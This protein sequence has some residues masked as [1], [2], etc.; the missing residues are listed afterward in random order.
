M[1]VIEVILQAK[2]KKQLTGLCVSF[3]KICRIDVLKTQKHRVVSL[4]CQEHLSTTQ[5]LPSLF[6]YA[7]LLS[8]PVIDAEKYL[9]LSARDRHTNLENQPDLFVTAGLGALYFVRNG[10][11]SEE[12]SSNSLLPSST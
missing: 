1:E 8:M 9:L 12:I 6:P 2:K 5:T 11:Q 4:P 7:N 3:W 10:N